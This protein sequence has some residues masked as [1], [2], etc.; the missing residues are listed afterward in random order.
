M[1]TADVAHIG[2]IT[3][4][5]KIKIASYDPAHDRIRESLLAKEAL[6]RHCEM[7]MEELRQLLHA[8]ASEAGWKVPDG[9]WNFNPLIGFHVRQRVEAMFIS[10]IMQ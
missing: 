9:P 6:L 8:T 1:H 3:M 4:R 5:G 2:E 10:R 7:E